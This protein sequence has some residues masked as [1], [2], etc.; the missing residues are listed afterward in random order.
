MRIIE[1]SFE[2][3]DPINQADGIRL[4]QKIERMARISHRSEEKQTPETWEK[5]I[6]AVVVDRADWSVA[7]HSSATVIFRMDRAICMEMVRHRHFSYTMESTRFV[8]Y[9]GDMEFIMPT[10]MKTDL[11]S[12]E[13]FKTSITNA[14]NDYHFLLERGG[15]PQEARAVLP[16]AL[17]AT[18]AVTGNLRAWRWLFLARTTR[19][20]HLDFR[21]ITIPLLEQFQQ[22]IPVIYEDIL[23][24]ARQVENAERAH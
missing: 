13:L 16:N 8:R 1:P 24:G 14:E 15:R 23:P 21:R 2:I 12:I 7:E 17:A 10:D 18:I 3:V 9:R 11:K 20:S 4:L 6:R 22:L 19:E 5:F